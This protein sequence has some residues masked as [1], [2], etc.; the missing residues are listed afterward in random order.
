[1]DYLS[2][3]EKLNDQI[4]ILVH[5]DKQE[6]VLMWYEAQLEKVNEA[7]LRADIYFDEQKKTNPS[8]PDCVAGSHAGRSVF[9]RSSTSST[10][11]ALEALAKAVAAHLKAKQQ[12]LEELRKKEE[13]QRQV[14]LKRQAEKA[15]EE[16]NRAQMEAELRRKTQEVEDEAICLAAE[17]DI[18][19]VILSITQKI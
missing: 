18:L 15:Q 6:E 14:E 1:M 12:V 19:R 10:S 11:R 2:Q 5:E 3:A 8:P 13:Y 16:L 9:S 7:K 4:L 17:A